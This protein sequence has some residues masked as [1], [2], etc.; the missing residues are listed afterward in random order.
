[1]TARLKELLLLRVSWSADAAITFPSLGGS[2]LSASGDMIL[3]FRLMREYCW[4]DT[5]RF[6]SET[7]GVTKDLF[8]SVISNMDPAFDPF[9]IALSSGKDDDDKNTSN[10]EEQTQVLDAIILCYESGTIWINSVKSSNRIIFMSYW[11]SNKFE[12]PH[13]T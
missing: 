12:I 6:S 7:R 5:P 1:M 2:F 3:L 4:G 13:V 8:L 11:I 10:N 9:I